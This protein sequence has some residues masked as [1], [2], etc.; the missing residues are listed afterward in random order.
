MTYKNK[1]WLIIPIVLIIVLGTL[2]IY[3]YKN[4]DTST[5]TNIS[6]DTS[7]EDI[8]WDSYEEENIELSDS[9]SITSPRVYTLTGEINGNVTINTSGNVKLILNGVTITSDN[10]QSL[11]IEYY[12]EEELHI[13]G[14]GHFFYEVKPFDEIIKVVKNIKRID[15]K[16][17]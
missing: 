17:G 16:V 1:I 15:I 9:L 4:K 2:L 7:S 8:N 5:D 3:H 12:D 14:E 13:S 11:N 6:I 10:G